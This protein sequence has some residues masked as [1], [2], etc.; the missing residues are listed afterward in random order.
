MG[1]L[2]EKQKL[3]VKEYLIDFNATRAAKAAGYS[4]KTAYAMGKENLRKP[5]IKKLLEK[6]KEKRNKRVNLSAD[7]V[8]NELRRIGFSNEFDL[9][10]FNKLDMKDKI[11]ALELLARHTGAFN[12]DKSNEQV[13]KVSFGN[14]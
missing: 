2:T 1:K 7:L 9:E 14:D 10:G 12:N 6:E 8:I 3:F 4:E 13:I 5:Q 11:K